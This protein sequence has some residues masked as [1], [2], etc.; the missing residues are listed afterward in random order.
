MIC[1]I[2][3]LEGAYSENKFC[4][5]EKN[6]REI[7]RWKENILRI[8]S[9]LNIKHEK[10]A[11]LNSNEY[12]I[13]NSIQITLFRK[14]KKS[15]MFHEIV[16][17][18]RSKKIK[19]TENESYIICFRNRNGIYVFTPCGHALLCELCCVT[20]MSQYDDGSKKLH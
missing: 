8:I 13:L 3:L 18:K 7:I 14:E 16:S 17:Q 20:L 12:R 10:S 2:K 5:F 11:K 4:S 19:I 6:F 9:F 1:I 15:K